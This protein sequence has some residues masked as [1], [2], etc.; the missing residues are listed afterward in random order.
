MFARRIRVELVSAEGARFCPLEWLDTY[1][2]R[3]FTGRST[4]DDVL[5]AADGVVEAGFQVDL[6]TLKADMEDW[7][8]KRFG[9]GQ[10]VKLSLT[11]VL[12]RP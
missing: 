7:F 1:C 6:G 3:S 5:P 11:E 4:L 9:R 12:S 8:T 10:T 2:M